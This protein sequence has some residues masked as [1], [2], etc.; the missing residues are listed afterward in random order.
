[1][2]DIISN[3]K[4]LLL[5]LILLISISECIGQSCLKT[6]HNNPSKFYLYFMAVL[7]YSIVC[8]LLVMSYK[9]KGMGIVNVLWSGISVLVVVSAGILFF[10]ESITNLD[11]IG[12]LLVV[13]GITCIIWEGDHFVGGHVTNGK[14]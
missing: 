2:N 14:V 5:G 8:L 3:P 4:I 7:F 6:Y 10:N 12:I 11:K 13:A 1:M 9:Y